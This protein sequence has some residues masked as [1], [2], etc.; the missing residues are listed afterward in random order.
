MGNRRQVITVSGRPK[1]CT[2]CVMVFCISKV[3][4]TAKG[5]GFKQWQLL[6]IGNSM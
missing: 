3:V 1:L 5:S 2:L 4:Q 6:S